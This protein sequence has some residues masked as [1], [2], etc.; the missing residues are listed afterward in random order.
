[1]LVTNEIEEKKQEIKEI[2]EDIAENMRYLVENKYLLQ[3]K[4]QRKKKRLQLQIAVLISDG[5]ESTMHRSLFCCEVARDATG[6]RSQLARHFIW[7][8]HSCLAHCVWIL[9]R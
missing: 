4:K 8:G 6:L 1:M 9:G 5:I 3:L 7:A 2:S